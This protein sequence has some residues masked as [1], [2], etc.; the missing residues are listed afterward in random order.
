MQ[1]EPM[2]AK[3]T[4][5]IDQDIPFIKGVLEPYAC[6]RYIAGDKITA[7]DLKASDILITRTR[8]K[9]NRDLLENSSVKLIATATIGFDHIDL[10]YCAQRGIKV[11]SAAG[12]NARGVLQY[13]IGALAWLSVQ[14]GWKPQQKTLGVVGVGNVGSLIAQYGRSLGFRILCCDPPKK[15]NDQSLD[16]IS[17][18]EL[19]PQCDIIT[20]HIPF[21]PR[22]AET[23]EM[24]TEGISN[25]TFFDQ[26]RPGAIF[27][28]SSRG[29]VMEDKALI[30]AIEAQK[31]SHAVID[32]WNN[33]PNINPTLLQLSTLATPHIAGY[34]I[35]GKAAATAAVV[36][37]CSNFLGLPL[38][39]WS[40][41]EVEKAIPKADVSWEEICDRTPAY[42]NIKEQ[43]QTL[44]STPQSFESLRNNYIFRTEFF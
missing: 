42:F 22:G 41:P 26:I 20:L 17:L 19:L 2:N 40:P 27:I 39:N 12:C 13:V 14:E 5:V 28:N 6:V 23:P 21:T 29:A 7:T 33:E 31:I 35:Q 18:A 37:S 34:S 36:R 30:E 15:L 38:N 16:Y 10:Q 44:K 25:R 3:P 4:I 11:T 8:T 9:C 1:S 32:T 24:A 43:S